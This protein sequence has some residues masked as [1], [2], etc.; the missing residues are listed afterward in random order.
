[1]SANKPI[2]RVAIFSDFFSSLGGT[3]YYNSLL[4]EKLS[5]RGIEVKIF[6]G[7]KPRLTYW[8]ELLKAKGLEIISP[9]EF[10]GDKSVRDIERHFVTKITNHFRTW[11]P[12]VIHSHP[13]GK[14]LL[15]WLELNERPQVPIV[16]T[17]WT[18]PS[19]LTS[20]WFLPEIKNFQDH[21]KAYIAP[22][23]AV[24]DGIRN[25]HGYKGE[26]RIIPH[27]IM[28]PL[29]KPESPINGSNISV[30]C[31]SR[32]AV[33]K[34]LDF[35]MG[36]WVKVVK[37]VPQATLHL[38]GHGPDEQRLKEMSQCLGIKNS[39][40]FEGVFQPI[41]G[42]DTVAARHP[43][44]VQPSL[45]ESVPTSVIE[46]MGRGRAIVA[47]SVG[48]LPELIGGGSPCGVLVNPG[49]TEALGNALICLIT[50]AG[51]TSQFQMSAQR[52]FLDIYNVEKV[53]DQI[54]D[55]YKSVTSPF[56]PTFEG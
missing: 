6:S 23:E 18:T 41:T 1:M 39:V 47:S 49:D 34:G 35:L 3:E 14:L 55:V 17:E 26:V 44:F 10:H 32:F 22:C 4:A 16:A 33:E 46:L 21:I 20:H 19:E 8:Q 56:L 30:G 13:A 11:E 12:D 31:V 25:Y 48:G 50:E 7:E 53:T 29:K 40:H 28:P 54:I 5:V 9:D 27:L 43:I 15:S 2:Q 42:I 38:Y 45:F 52:K 24:H 51:L 36:A 37:S